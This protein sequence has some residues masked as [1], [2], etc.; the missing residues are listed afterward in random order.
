MKKLICLLVACFILVQSSTAYAASS[1]GKY[2]KLVVDDYVL[3]KT[4][5]LPGEE[6]TIS[7]SIRNTSSAK[8]ARN[9]RVSFKDEAGEILPAKTASS[10]IP[11]IGPDSTIEWQIDVFVTET[12]KDAPHIVN[13]KMEYEDKQG[14]QLTAEDTITIDVVQ[15]VRMEYTEP[16]MPAKVTQGDT[17]SLSLTLM[18]MGKGDIYNALLTYNIEGLSNGGSVLVGTISP[19]A[20]KEGTTNLRVNSDAIGDVSG[21]IT[22][23][24]ED[25]R[26]KYYETVLPVSTVIEEKAISTYESDELGGSEN[27]GSWKILAIGFGC[28]SVLLLFVSLSAIAKGRKIRKEYELKL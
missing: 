26:G 24:Y 5:L 19:G 16:D 22:L 20:S 9:I 1:D 27:D 28:L 10:I 12:A 18:N 3:E 7:I 2:P 17:F 11:Y 13:I 14:N 21:D 4:S 15:L 23:S 8:S 25:S 6:T